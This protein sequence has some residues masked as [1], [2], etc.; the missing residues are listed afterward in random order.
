[1]IHSYFIDTNNGTR[2]VV[3][4]RSRKKHL[5]FSK[6]GT[7]FGDNRFKVLRFCVCGVMFVGNNS[8][9]VPE[10]QDVS[11]D[12]VKQTDS[13]NLRKKTPKSCYVIL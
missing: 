8:I 10:L 12:P 4:W 9:V 5:E 6:A 3:N 7:S 13:E 11:G 2:K 1:M